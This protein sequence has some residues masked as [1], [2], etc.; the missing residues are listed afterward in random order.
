MHGRSLQQLPTSHHEIGIDGTAPT[1]VVCVEVHWSN[2]MVK[3]FFALM[4]GLVL[5]GPVARADQCDNATSQVESTDCAD[6]AFNKADAELNSIY[7]ELSAAYKK[8]DVV[9]KKEQPDYD[10]ARPALVSAQK[11]WIAFRDAECDL[12]G[13]GPQGGTA[14]PMVIAQ[15][16][17]RLT[18]DRIKQ[19]RARLKCDDGNMGCLQLGDGAN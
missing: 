18:L 16:L 2:G 5:L 1:G 4:L 19:L 6:L 14:R 7:G 11:N 9:T 3:A 13:L 10:L 15:C 12:E 17:E 8:L